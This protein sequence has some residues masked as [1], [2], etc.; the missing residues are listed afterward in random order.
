MQFTITKIASLLVF[1]FV[2]FSC[3]QG[4]EDSEVKTTLSGSSNS[5]RL[6]PLYSMVKDRAPRKQAWDIN[7]LLVPSSEYQRLKE[8][9]YK[10]YGV[11]GATDKPIGCI[12]PADFAGAKSWGGVPIYRGVD[13]GNTSNHVHYFKPRGY[14]YEKLLGYAFNHD[15]TFNTMTSS[16]NALCRFDFPQPDA[17]GVFD[18]FMTLCSEANRLR[19]LTINGS[20]VSYH[21]QGLNVISGPK[22]IHLVGAD[23]QQKLFVL[24]P[25]NCQ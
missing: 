23:A 12:M 7:H 13:P 8:M 25:N 22:Y 4:T 2:H 9:G 6:I 1:G 17:M 15:D 18:D 20:G 11:Q 24:S 3:S 14:R 21:S 10:A 19:G 16:Y 5:L